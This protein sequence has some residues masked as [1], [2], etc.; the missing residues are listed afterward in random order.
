MKEEWKEE[1]FAEGRRDSGRSDGDPVK[2]ANVSEHCYEECNSIGLHWLFRLRLHWGWQTGLDL[3]VWV[4]KSHNRSKEAV[5]GFLTLSIRVL[6]RGL[7][8]SE[9]LLHTLKFHLTVSELNFECQ[10]L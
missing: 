10:L 9:E 5:R 2:S 6:R 1:A 4:D 8:D 7:S 3:M